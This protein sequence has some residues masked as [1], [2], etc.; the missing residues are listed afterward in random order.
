MF[1]D[2]IYTFKKIIF[3]NVYTFLESSGRF[4]YVCTTFLLMKSGSIYFYYYTYN[5]AYVTGS[6]NL[7]LYSCNIYELT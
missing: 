6:T 4:I 3:R 5:P 7:A 1:A 2:D